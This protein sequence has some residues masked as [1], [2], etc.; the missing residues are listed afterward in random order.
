M[1]TT[2]N[3]FGLRP[4]YSPSGIV[5]PGPLVQIASAAPFDIFQNSPIALDTN[6]NLILA[7]PGDR[8]IGT[9]QGVEFTD[10]EQRFRVSNR[11]VA[12]TVATDIRAYYIAAQ[13][14]IVYEIQAN[15][16]LTEAAIGDQYDWTAIAGNAITGLSEVALDVATAAGPGGNAGL[17]VI[18]L[19][20]GPDNAWG[21]PFPVV[22]VQVSEHQ[23]TADEAA[24]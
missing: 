18:G 9:F 8:A 23:F 13:D 17:R 7:A 22:L 16:S 5:R 20:P 19:N 2:L 15:A 6:G 21:D 11:W 10:V 3:P 14:T 12:N 1:S 24:I 4:A